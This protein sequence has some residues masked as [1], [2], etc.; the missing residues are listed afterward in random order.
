MKKQTIEIGVEINGIEEAQQKAD[1]LVK[2]LEKAKTLVDELALAEILN[3][4][5]NLKGMN[6]KNAID[7]ALGQG[8][9]LTRLA[10]KKDSFE[11]YVIPT[12]TDIG[13]ILHNPLEKRIE[14]KLCP[15]WQPNSDDLSATDWIV[16]D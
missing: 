7:K 14:N 15:G 16:I 8:K 13:M 12:R 10:W 2:T 1:K 3:D 4:G 5:A 11:L 9:M 6:V